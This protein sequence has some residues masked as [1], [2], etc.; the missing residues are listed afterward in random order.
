M[1]PV[2]VGRVEDRQQQSPQSHEFSRDR[3]SVQRDVCD[4]PTS[5]VPIHFRSTVALAQHSS[6][7]S[8]ESPCNHERVTSRATNISSVSMVATV[9]SQLSSYVQSSRSIVKP[10]PELPIC[11]S[12][13][14]WR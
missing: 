10:S 11:V 9:L 12:I 14:T 1:E 13:Q 7:V 5:H 6:A 8:S 3:T 4:V 2:L